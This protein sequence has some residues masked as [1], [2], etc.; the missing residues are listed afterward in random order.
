[1]ALCEDES[2]GLARVGRVPRK[3]T[4]CAAGLM[5]IGSLLWIDELPVGPIFTYIRSCRPGIYGHVSLDGLRHMRN[6]V[7]RSRSVRPPP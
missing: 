5:C 7:T 4:I 2:C 6:E 3:C 1:M